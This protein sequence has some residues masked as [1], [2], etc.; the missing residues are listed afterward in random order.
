VELLTIAEIARRLNIPE[1]TVRYYRDR[2]AAYIP[3][4]GEGRSRRYKSETIEV[5]RFIS[6]SMKAGIPVE[7]IESMLQARFSV[8][9]E[10][11]QQSSGTQQQSS[12][13]ILREMLGDA[14]RD[15]L[16]QHATAIREEMALREERLLTE[17]ATVREENQRLREVIEQ[18][19]QTLHEVSTTLS[20]VETYGKR[21][22]WKRLFS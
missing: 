6:D 4:I 18:Y 9:V 22:W 14:M 7:D 11:Q 2:F 8:N 17:I 21:S 5:I 19:N 1:S 3:D 16:E 20:R 15:I 10:P 13:M 12:A